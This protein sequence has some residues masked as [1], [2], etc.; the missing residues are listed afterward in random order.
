MK[1]NCS[2]DLHKIHFSTNLD[3]RCCTSSSV[4]GGVLVMQIVGEISFGSF[5]FLAGCAVTG[6]LQSLL[7]LKIFLS[8]GFIY[9]KSFLDLTACTC[10]RLVLLLYWRLNNIFPVF[11]QRLGLKLWALWSMAASKVLPIKLGY[12][13]VRKKVKQ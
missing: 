9:L 5:G 7:R 6:S 8:N 11:E 1:I 3:S 10:H 2:H 12:L 13:E 4:D